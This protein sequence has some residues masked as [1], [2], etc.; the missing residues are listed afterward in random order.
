[1][2]DSVNPYAPPDGPALVSSG[3]LQYGAPAPWE[4]S[5]IVGTAWESFKRDWT[6]LV[7]VAV[8]GLG[9]VVLSWAIFFLLGLP[10]A[11]GAP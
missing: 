1:M 10:F 11:I 2:T 4:V 7:L 3:A 8:I 6:S 5:E 9:M